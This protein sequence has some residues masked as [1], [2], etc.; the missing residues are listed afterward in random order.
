MSI[1]LLIMAFVSHC[2]LSKELYKI[3]NEIQKLK[4]KKGDTDEQNDVITESH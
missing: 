2:A 1:L 3:K 4:E